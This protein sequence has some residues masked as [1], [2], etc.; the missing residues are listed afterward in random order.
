ME[1]YVMEADGSNPIRLTDDPAYDTNPAW[2]PDGHYIAFHS[3]RDGAAEIYI[4]GAEGSNPLP[5][6]E[7]DVDDWYPVW[8]P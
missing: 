2:S 7:N 1:I 6:T 8:G 3:E 4:M 5:L